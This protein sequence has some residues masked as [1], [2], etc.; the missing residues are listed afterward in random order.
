MVRL[1]FRNKCLQAYSAVEG[2]IDQ[3]VIPVIESIFSSEVV[4]YIPY[5]LQI[6]GKFF[7]D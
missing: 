7:F 5:A 4:D 1:E 2:G 6:T 3:Y